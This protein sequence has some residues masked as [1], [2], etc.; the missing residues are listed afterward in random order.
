METVAEAATAID[1]GF[2]WMLVEIFGH[3]THWGRGIEV[4]RFGS[5]MLRIDVPEIEWSTPTEEKPAP[6]PLIKGW[7]THFYGGAAIFSNTL[8][9]ERTV[10]IRNAPYGEPALYLAPPDRNGEQAEGI[11][12]SQAA[13]DDDNDPEW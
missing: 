1:E 13:V 6:E 5:K 7:V 11:D 4:E 2:E 9:D 12:P 10:L 3:R 8:T